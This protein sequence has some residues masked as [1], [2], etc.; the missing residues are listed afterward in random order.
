M[1]TVSGGP[2]SL[3]DE[4]SDSFEAADA[5]SSSSAESS[6]EP[7]TP[8]LYLCLYHCISYHKYSLNQM[9]LLKLTRLPQNICKVTL[10]A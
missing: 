6:N 10:C 2:L 3:A 5:E 8:W 7:V 4:S 1:S 9:A